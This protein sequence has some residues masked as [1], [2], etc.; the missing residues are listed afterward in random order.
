MIDDYKSEVVVLEVNLLKNNEDKS[1]FNL[2]KEEVIKKLSCQIGKIYDKVMEVRR[3]SVIRFGSL[4]I[5]IIFIIIY[6]LKISNLQI[7]FTPYLINQIS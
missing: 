4:L 3:R 6:F 5:S 1:Y 2:Q 7:R